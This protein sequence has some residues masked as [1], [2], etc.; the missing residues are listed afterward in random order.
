MKYHNNKNK[1]L[2]N[3][4]MGLAGESG[5]LIDI[6]K[7]HIFHGHELNIEEIK[8]ECGDVLWYLA[9]IASTLDLNLDDICIY[10]IKKLEK[11]YPE[12][13]SKEKSINREV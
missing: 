13:F 3:Y 1:A 2:A 10:N 11:R 12:G 6:L 9:A 5:E 4:S 7:K 8:K